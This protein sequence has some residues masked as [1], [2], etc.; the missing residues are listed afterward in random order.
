MCTT[1]RW[2]EFPAMF[3]ALAFILTISHGNSKLCGTLKISIKRENSTAFIT[4][5]MAV[6]ERRFFFASSGY[7]PY[8]ALSEVERQFRCG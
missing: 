6:I 8:L 1:W 5:L 3:L 4:S 7:L 2:A